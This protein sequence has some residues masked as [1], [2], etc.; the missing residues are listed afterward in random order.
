MC[1]IHFLVIYKDVKN[2]DRNNTALQRELQE[3]KD[4]LVERWQCEETP[5]KKLKLV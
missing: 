3:V 5:A 2:Q 1:H 4:N